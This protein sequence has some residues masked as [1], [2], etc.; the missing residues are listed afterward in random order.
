M[1][2]YGDKHTKDKIMY[3]VRQNNKKFH[4]SSVF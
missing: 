4:L 1:Q 2:K 3:N